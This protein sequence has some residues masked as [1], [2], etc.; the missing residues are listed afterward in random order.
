[1]QPETSEQEIER[2]EKAFQA[3]RKQVIEKKKVLNREEQIW[4]EV[5][6]A[7]E[8]EIR[9]YSRLDR[10]LAL[11]KARNSKPL[12]L[13]KTY[14]LAKRTA[15]KAIKALGSLPKELRDKILTDM[16]DGLF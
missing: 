1:M 10:E 16:K 8:D 7:Y 11:A 15:D 4:H 2:L 6:R 3:S 5:K 9:E 13:T 12:K 14:D